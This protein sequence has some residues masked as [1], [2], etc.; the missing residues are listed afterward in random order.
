[1][2]LIFF[3]HINLRSFWFIE[4]SSSA[5]YYLLT[6]LLLALQDHSPTS[7]YSSLRRIFV[8][9]FP[10]TEGRVSAGIYPAL[11]VSLAVPPGVCGAWLASPSGGF[12]YGLTMWLGCYPYIFASLLISAFCSYLGFNAE[13][14]GVMIRRPLFLRWARVSRAHIAVL[15][16]V[17]ICVTGFLCWGRR[18]L[19]L[20]LKEAVWVHLGALW[21]MSLKIP[22]AV[23]Q[24]ISLS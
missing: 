23:L 11:T 10:V 9:V 12:G 4:H 8:C 21:K 7:G 17:R 2:L 22:I 3:P 15:L 19:D 13:L 18:D 14:L 24:R 5:I 6:L 1:M 16:G 20:P